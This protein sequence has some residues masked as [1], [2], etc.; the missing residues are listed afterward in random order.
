MPTEEFKKLLDREF[1]KASVQPIVE[2]AC[3]IRRTDGSEILRL[4]LGV[5]SEAVAAS[6]AVTKTKSPTVLARLR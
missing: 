3:P 6:S 5:P 1:S 2:I 4:L